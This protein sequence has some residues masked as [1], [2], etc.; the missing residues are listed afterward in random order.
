VI[1]ANNGS[2][3]MSGTVDTYNSGT[4]VMTVIIATSTGSGTYS[5][6]SVNL[7]GAVGAVGATGVTGATGLST[8]GATGPNGNKYATVYL[9]QWASTQP[10]DPSDVST[11]TW[12]TASNA[13][14]TGGNGWST[15]VAANP[16]GALVKLW[17]AAKSI[18]DVGNATTTSVDWSSGFSVSAYGQNGETGATGIT[19]LKTAKA[20]VYKW[21]LPPAPSISGTSTYTWASGAITSPPSGWDISITTAPSS[22]YTLWSAT[23][24]L[25][26]SSTATTTSIDW[27]SAQILSIGYSGNDG[28]TGPN[29]SSS[30]IAYARIAGSPTP[31]S[32]TV[33]TSGGSSYPSGSATWGTSF[34]T[35]WSG[36]DPDPS[37]NNSLFQT[38]GVYNGTNTVWDTPF[39][40]SLRVGQL[41]AI[42]TNTGTLTINSG[43]YLAA[44][45][46]EISSTTMTGAGAKIYAGG[47]F[48][49]GNTSTNISFNGTQMTLNGNVVATSNIN[50]NAVTQIAYVS[51]NT[52]ITAPTGV[53]QTVTIAATGA[54]ILVMASGRVQGNIQTGSPVLGQ[55]TVIL[56]RDGAPPALYLDLYSG[57]GNDFVFTTAMG[58]PFN[59]S[60]ID[61]PPAGNV[62]YN[63]AVS[64]SSNLTGLI[65]M[66]YA[67]IAL[68]EVKR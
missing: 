15:T 14:Y 7:A 46:A 57:T 35:T 48:A 49:M 22:G 25:Q 65:S 28:A 11:W 37:S 4:G 13:S 67:T 43:G 30:R 61:T 63:I 38:Y 20:I 50:N 52:A 16:G 5:S 9:Y 10:G 66:D 21:S 58:G 59:C 45:N 41:S 29:G 62:T 40:A 53:L 27:T 33:T 54:P 1:I 8:T 68:L 55:M 17:V 23:A 42:T 24:S 64:G 60:V 18:S 44:G 26:D 6:W 34:N 31:V 19:G 3:Y 56:I 2:N 39:L 32:G 51:G 36:S 12:S 47:T